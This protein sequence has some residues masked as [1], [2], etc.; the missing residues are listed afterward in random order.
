M[1][2]PNPFSSASAY[3]HII[4]PKLVLGTTGYQVG[5]DI[6]NIDIVYSRQLGGGTA[7]QQI[8]QAYIQQI[9]STGLSGQ[10]YFNQVGS[11]GSSG[12]GYFNTIYWNQF[13]PSLPGGGGGAGGATLIAGPGIALSTV[14][15]G[16]L[17]QSQIQVGQGLTINTPVNG[18][19]YVISGNPYPNFVGTTGIGITYVGNTYTFSSTIG[20]TGSQYIDVQQTGSNFV[21]SYNGSQTGNLA[22]SGTLGAYAVF[23]ASGLQASSVLN[24]SNIVGPSGQV[25]LY[26]SKGPTGS[27]LLNLNPDGN[28]QT[29]FTPAQMISDELIPTSRLRILKA[30]NTSYLQSGKT[31]TGSSEPLVISG[32]YGK[33]QIAKFDVPSGLVTINPSFN[34]TFPDYPNGATL[35]YSGTSSGITSLSVGSY[36]VYMWGGGG[37]GLSGFPGGA[38]G[39]VGLTGINIAAPTTFA[40]NRIDTP[41]GGSTIGL[42]IAGATAAIAPGGG[43]GGTGGQGAAFGEPGGSYPGQ[44]YSASTTGATTGGTGG[45]SASIKNQPTYYTLGAIGV[46]AQGAKFQNVPVTYGL[47]GTIAPGSIIRGFGVINEVVGSSQTTFYFPPGSTMNIQTSGMTF[48]NSA[49]NL[50]GVTGGVF[51]GFYENLGII[52]VSGQYN[53]FP[54]GGTAITDPNSG[55]TMQFVGPYVGVSGASFQNA[56][57][58]A[59]ILNSQVFTFSTG[60]TMTLPNGITFNS[61]N[62]PGTIGLEI[63]FQ[64][65]DTFTFSQPIGNTSTSLVQLNN[66]IYIP[67]YSTIQVSALSSLVR[68]SQGSNTLGGFYGGGAGFYGGGGGINGG[69]GGAGGALIVPGVTG[70][71]QSGSGTT[72]FINYYNYSGIYG[73]GGSGTAGGAPY[74]VIEKVTGGAQPNVLQVN[75]NETVSGTLNVQNNA[76]INGTGNVLTTNGSILSSGAVQAPDFTGINPALTA[77]QAANFSQGI[78]FSNPTLTIANSIRSYPPVGSIIMYVAYSVAPQGWLLCDGKTYFSSA[79]PA[80]GALLTAAGSPFDATGALGGTPAFYV[81]DLRSRVPIGIASVGAPVSTLT[82][83]SLGQTGGFQDSTLPAHTHTIND[84]GHFHTNGGAAGGSVLVGAGANKADQSNTGVAQTGITI[85]STGTN[86]TGTN[87]PPFLAVAFII[88]T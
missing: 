7:S 62:I 78:S 6:A 38:G 76:V 17:V 44:G 58:F 47:T 56:T 66:P 83:Y 68:G 75:G 18:A 72:P 43:A 28:V 57:G 23:G 31:T 86:P 77:V 53:N 82:P 12:N 13:V 52:G 5:V 37:A 88:K 3:D 49:Y 54:L 69:G 14:A 48:A 74:Y 50:S 46:T 65:V 80:L 42:S 81:P 40:F 73:A 34:N 41:N 27:P 61:F 59:Q 9:G 36:N 85:N 11:P 84:P 32:M 87:L 39:F 26:S 64:G 4:N 63:D 25:M 51:N 30:G 1:T 55:T 70:S 19:P 24:S 20:I 29:L 67:P 10:A 60:I 79:F 22:P 16:Q 33:P 45:T 21:V 15:G 35:L 71:V 8:Q 2:E